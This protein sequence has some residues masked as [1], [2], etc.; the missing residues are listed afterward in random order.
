[1]VRRT[2]LKLLSQASLLTAQTALNSNT[3]EKKGPHLKAGSGKPSKQ[4]P[5]AETAQVKLGRDCLSSIL[6]YMDAECPVPA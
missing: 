5:N 6:V 2:M 4:F 1:M 3:D